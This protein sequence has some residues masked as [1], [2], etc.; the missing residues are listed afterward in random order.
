MPPPAILVLDRDTA[1]V[2]ARVAA[3]RADL[4]LVDALARVQLAAV[5]RGRR[6]RCRDVGPELGGLLE[7]VGLAG[8][9]AGGPG[10]GAGTRGERGGG[11]GG[12]APPPPPRQPPPPHTPPRRGRRR[13]R[14]G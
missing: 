13:P 4:A 6:V 14:G 5:R 3:P 12:A 2:V 10:G 9:L 11:G 8:V 1:E 7:L